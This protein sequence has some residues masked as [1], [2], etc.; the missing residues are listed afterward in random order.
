[1]IYKI[2]SETTSKWEETYTQSVEEFA[3]FFQI[4]KNKVRLPH[5][6]LVPDRKTIDSLRAQP[7][8]DWL[9][10]WYGNGN[11]YLL[12]D[13][14]FE[15]ESSH[16]YSDEEYVALMRHELVHYFSDIVSNASKKPV[17]LIEGLAIYLSGQNEFKKK[18]EV[19]E[20]FI[21]FFDHGG[22]CV[23]TESGFAVMFLV[24]K[25]GKE[26][27]LDLLKQSKECITPDDFSK[28]FQK[29]YGF[30]LSYGNFEVL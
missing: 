23:Y 25:H 12:E 8:E 2:N 16:A 30:E 27:L 18:P 17:W 20:N 10:G 9:V 13:K 28:L 7:S 4:D 3:E 24:G 14:S 22:R 5:I 21:E 1:M 11:I 19:L 29:I 26:K 6:F 15:N